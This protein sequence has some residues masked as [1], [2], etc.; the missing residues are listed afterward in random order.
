MS[1][2]YN[3]YETYKES[4]YANYEQ[5][6]AVVKKL[7]EWK[8][9]RESLKAI[10]LKMENRNIIAKNLHELATI[11][12]DEKLLN[13]AKS[14]S[15][16]HSFVTNGNIN[17]C[18]KPYCPFCSADK[19]K[20]FG[21]ECLKTIYEM[22]DRKDSVY[23]LTLAIHNVSLDNLGNAFLQLNELMYKVT[24]SSKATNIIKWYCYFIELDRNRDGLYRP[25]VNVIYCQNTNRVKGKYLTIQDWEEIGNSFFKLN[26]G[27]QMSLKLE[28]LS[29]GKTIKETRYQTEAKM[30]Y[31]VKG[32][33]GDVV[34]DDDLAKYLLNND[35]LQWHGANTNESYSE[36]RAKKESLSNSNSTF[37][38]KD[39]QENKNNLQEHNTKK[40]RDNQSHTNIDY[41]GGV[42]LM[43]IL[44]KFKKDMR[45]EIFEL[46]AS[47]EL[48]LHNLRQEMAELKKGHSNLTSKDSFESN[49]ISPKAKD[50]NTLEIE[51]DT[52]M[53]DRQ[54]IEQNI[55][56]D[57]DTESISAAA[58]VKEEKEVLCNANEE[59][60]TE[61]KKT[62]EETNTKETLDKEDDEYN[63][64]WF[65]P[66]GYSKEQYL[67][68]YK[69]YFVEDSSENTKVTEPRKIPCYKFINLQNNSKYPIYEINEM[70]SKVTE[71][72]N[73][74]YF[75]KLSIEEMQQNHKQDK[76][77]RNKYLILLDTETKEVKVMSSTV[78]TFLSNNPKDYAWRFYDEQIFMKNH[79]YGKDFV[80]ETNLYST[81][82]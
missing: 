41:V 17:K 71:Y 48:E 67:E 64:F 49:P 29:R 13:Q 12:E 65:L 82:Q 55:D 10:A 70:I 42:E 81:L 27:E 35:K 8:Y 28:N 78:Y 61:I 15:L 19:A 47:Y 74:G 53:S 39:L 9:D 36:K 4:K 20:S 11:H 62:Y 3:L 6:K 57:T 1:V 34:V 44:D 32:F 58:E 5:G 72:M 31:I 56:K 26:K 45:K 38:K 54:D 75:C 63:E 25:H 69:E 7:K 23:A 73:M 77:C 33:L 2:K 52:N 59:T 50:E 18:H 68:D 40:E 79:K 46:K 43:T 76:R 21:D 22:I 66:E 16:C 60:N 80:H 24:K 37:P 14:V 30:S 51:S